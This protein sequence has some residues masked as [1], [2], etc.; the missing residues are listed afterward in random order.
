VQ[1]DIQAVLAAVRAQI[2]KSP[3]A[4]LWN[5][6]GIVQVRAGRI[7]DAKASYERAAGMGLV[8]AMI[9]RGNLALNEGDSAGARRWFQAALDKDPENAAA[10]RGMSS[11]K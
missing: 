2:A 8:A 4:A 11:L 3:T 5:R 7:A 6:L 9:N 10:L 1:S